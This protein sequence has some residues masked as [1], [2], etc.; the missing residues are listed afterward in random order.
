VRPS[1]S[2]GT[3]PTGGRSSITPA[4]HPGRVVSPI[5]YARRVHNPGVVPVVDGTTLLEANFPHGAISKLVAAD[6]RARD[7]VYQAHRWF[8][9]RPAALLRSLLLAAVLPGDTPNEDFW[10]LYRD[11]GAWLDGVAVFD[12]F[13]G[14]GTTLIEAARLGAE[15]MGS[16]IDPLA[17]LM[18]MHAADPPTLQDLDKASEDLLDHLHR[19]VGHLYPHSGS[20]L[21]LHT[22][23][24]AVV[25]CPDC[26]TQSPLYR[27]PVISRGAN[28]IGSVARSNG[29]TVF[30]PECSAL[31]T[32]PIG[33]KILRCCGRNLRLDQGTFSKH[34]FECPSCRRRSSHRDLATGLAPRRIVAIEETTKEGRRF[35]S[36]TEDDL[37]AAVRASQYLAERESQLHLPDGEFDPNRADLRP[38]SFGIKRFRELFSD[39]QLALFGTAFAWLQEREGDPRTTRALTLAVSNALATNNR[40]C[41]YAIDYGRLSALFSIRGYS[42]PAL[43]VELNALHPSAGRGTLPRVLARIRSSLSADV[44]RYVV[45]PGGEEIQAATRQFPR[46]SEVRVELAAA[47]SESSE[48]KER[49]SVHLVV[50]DPPYFDYIPYDELSAFYRAWLPESELAGSSLHPPTHGDRVTHFGVRLGRALASASRR[51]L[52]GGLLAF[53]YHSA[54]PDAWRAVAVALDEAKLRV[55]ALWPVL[56]D[57]HMGH[58]GMAGSCEHDLVV[59]TR[60]LSATRQGEAPC[61]REPDPAAAWIKQLCASLSTVDQENARLAYEACAPRWGRPTASDVDRPLH[62]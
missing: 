36:A 35:R 15:C 40:L 19:E 8:A 18:G 50:T 52:P 47:D 55:T 48:H 34:V 17:V 21:P 9:R 37:R 53:T 29:M 32:L 57:P 26:G 31:H 59:V 10:S 45:L 2:P 13:L 3:L 39:R 12:P 43:A 30:C 27:S 23:S 41:G 44:R 28:K 38:V 46:A 42:L 11:P 61:A 1:A 22:F 62:R 58:H 60:P 7:G 20:P 56:A 14:G 5:P 25:D 16:D 33:R 51:L 6:R 49:P 4:R 24:V 54:N